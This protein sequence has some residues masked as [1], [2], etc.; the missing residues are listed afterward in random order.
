MGQEKGNKAAD[1]A[2]RLRPDGATAIST[3]IA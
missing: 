2:V 1:H 3:P